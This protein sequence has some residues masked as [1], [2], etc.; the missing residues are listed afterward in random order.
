MDI[1]KIIPKS[2]DHI[3]F[4]EGEGAIRRLR[5]DHQHADVLFGEDGC[6]RHDAVGQNKLIVFVRLQKRKD[7]LEMRGVLRLRKADIRDTEHRGAKRGL[8]F[9]WEWENL[10][11]GKLP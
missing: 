1:R 4:I 3:L 11:T 6:V 2:L 8:L 5:V 10:G 9:R 7:V